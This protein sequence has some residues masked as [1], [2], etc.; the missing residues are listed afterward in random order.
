MS[1]N[2]TIM[3]I[4]VEA[5]GGYAHAAAVIRELHGVPVFGAGGLKMRDAGMALCFDLIE[6]VVVTM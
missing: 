5:S 2:P 4:A 1:S 3:F 6:H